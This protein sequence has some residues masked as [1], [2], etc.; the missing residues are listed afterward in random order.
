VIDLSKMDGQGRIQL[1]VV[2]RDAE[3]VLDERLLTAIKDAVKE[4]CSP[5]HVPDDV[6]VV[7]DIPRTLNGKKLEVPVKR[8]LS[9]ESAERVV[10]RGSMSNPE[11]MEFFIE[12]AE[13]SA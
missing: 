5:R 13:R 3:G 2:L 1:F 11:A 8:L 4:K 6:Y 7:D 10:N 12:L 9:G